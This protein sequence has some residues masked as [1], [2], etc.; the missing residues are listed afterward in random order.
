MSDMATEKTT[1]RRADS[2]RLWK[3]VAAFTLALGLTV[4]GCIKFD[5]AIVP[6]QA[7]KSAQLAQD[8][9]AR[10]Q[11]ALASA[12]SACAAASSSQQA[13]ASSYLAAATSASEMATANA[14]AAGA[15]QQKVDQAAAAAGSSSQ[16]LSQI[17]ELKEERFP[18]LEEKYWHF[19]QFFQPSGA[20]P[21]E[22]VYVGQMATASDDLFGE[23]WE[24][25]RDLL[26]ISETVTQAAYSP[27]LQQWAAEHPSDP[28]DPT[29]A[30]LAAALEQATETLHQDVTAL[31]GREV[32][33]DSYDMLVS[34]L[35]ET[36][37]LSNTSE[38]SNFRDLMNDLQDTAWDAM[39]I[40]D[41]ELNDAVRWLNDVNRNATQSANDA[42]EDVTQLADSS[43]EQSAE[44]TRNAWLAI[45]ACGGEIPPDLP[46]LQGPFSSVPSIPDWNSTFW[47]IS[48]P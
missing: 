37:I 15:A 2:G 4:S 5:Q 38:R 32:S 31:E 19:A 35:S 20:G 46:P 12:N 10:A 40:V 36:A 22:D 9:M 48:S 43:Y 21:R 13:S 25:R 29:P 33:V 8:N 30:D 17:T 1:A 6:Y 3:P 28:G 39:E 16:F 18:A 45:E 26:V 44:A 47:F 14:S 24:F 41:N 11:S 7:Q 27:E 23:L 34:D 42:A